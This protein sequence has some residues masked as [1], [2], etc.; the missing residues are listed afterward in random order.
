MHLEI[1]SSSEEESQMVTEK[2]SNVRTFTL[3]QNAGLL[4]SQTTEQKTR[5]SKIITQSKKSFQS[6]DEL[7]SASKCAQQ[8][9][10]EAALEISKKQANKL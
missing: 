7:L 6:E 3:D 5:I 10:A 2:K 8:N 4:E 9:Q 1:A